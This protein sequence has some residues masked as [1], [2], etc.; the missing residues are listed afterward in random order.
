MTAR[1]LPVITATCFEE[2]PHTLVL[3]EVAALCCMTYHGALYWVSQGRL[4]ARKAGGIWLIEK[5]SLLTYVKRE[6]FSLTY[7]KSEREF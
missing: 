3:C 1:E 7:G 4:K 6:G 2:L 5:T